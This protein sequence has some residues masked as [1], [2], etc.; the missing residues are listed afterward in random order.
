MLGALGALLRAYGGIWWQILA[1]LGGRLAQLGQSW[2]QVATKM[3]HDISKMGH[4]SCKIA[5]LDSTY[6]LGGGCRSI[7]D[8]FWH[9]GWRVKNQRKPDVYFGFFILLG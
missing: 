7:F 1:K 2:R 9:H 4:D 6:E 3:G 8:R 5:I